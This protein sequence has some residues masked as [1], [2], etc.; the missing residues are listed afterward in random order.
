[1]DNMVT[2]NIDLG[3]DAGAK[4]FRLKLQ[5]MIDQEQNHIEKTA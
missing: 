5:R 1:M 3:L 2:P 4:L